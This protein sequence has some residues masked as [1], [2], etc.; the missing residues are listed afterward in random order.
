MP[1]THAEIGI[2]RQLVATWCLAKHA[3]Q[4]PAGTRGTTALTRQLLTGSDRVQAA[5]A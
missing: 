5:E 3:R 2:A 1:A 4:Q